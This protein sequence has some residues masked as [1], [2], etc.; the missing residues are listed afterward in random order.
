MKKSARNPESEPHSTPDFIVRVFSIDS[1]D[2]EPRFLGTGFLVA[3]NCVVTCAHIFKQSDW[4]TDIDLESA[5][6]CVLSE[7]AEKQINIYKFAREY[8]TKYDLAVLELE[9]SI[10]SN[11]PH[12][13][14]NI[15]KSHSS[16]LSQA[17]YEY[18]G[19]AASDNAD[20]YWDEP[21]VFKSP[22]FSAGVLRK[23]RLDGGIESG[24]SGSP[25]I[26]I[27]NGQ[28][29]CVGMAVVSGRDAP[30]SYIVPFDTIANFLESYGVSLPRYIDAESFFKIDQPAKALSD[31]TP[32]NSGEEQSTT[33]RT[34]GRRIS[35]TAVA[36]IFIVA[37]VGASEIW[38]KEEHLPLQN[39]MADMGQAMMQCSTPQPAD[40][41]DSQQGLRILVLSLHGPDSESAAEGLRIG[42]RLRFDIENYKSVQENLP[43]WKQAHLRTTALYTHFAPCPVTTHEAARKV[44]LAQQYDLVIWGQ[45]L[46]KS[47]GSG[48]AYSVHSFATFTDYTSISPHSSKPPRKNGD[49]QFTLPKQLVP[50][51]DIMLALYAYEKEQ[52]KVATHYFRKSLEYIFDTE[53]AWRL[54]LIASDAFLLAKENDVQDTNKNL[55]EKV[56]ISCAGN[57]HCLA[58]YWETIA[59]QHTVRGELKEA[60]ETYQERALPKAERIA[61]ERLRVNILMSIAELNAYHGNDNEA[62]AAALKARDTLS[63]LPQ[64]SLDRSYNRISGWL[65]LRNGKYKEAIDYYKRALRLWQPAEGLA[66]KGEMLR[67]IADAYQAQGDIGNAILNFQDSLEIWEKLKDTKR[68]AALQAEL[69]RI[70]FYKKVDLSKAI[71]YLRPASENFHSI[72]DTQNEARALSI[73][74][75]SYLDTEQDELSQNALRKIV[76][77]IGSLGELGVDGGAYECLAELFKHAGKLSKAIESINKA[78]KILQISREDAKMLPGLYAKKAGIEIKA[79]EFAAALVSY[80]EEARLYMQQGNSTDAYYTMDTICDLASRLHKPQI[81]D[82]LIKEIN[83]QHDLEYHKII[84]TARMLVRLGRH[85][86]ARTLFR[87]LSQLIEFDKNKPWNTDEHKRVINL[88]AQMNIARI[89]KWDTFKECMGIIVTNATDESRA[90]P[91]LLNPG[92][93]ITEL[94]GRCVSSTELVLDVARDAYNK[95]GWK[96]ISA[97][98]WRNGKWIKTTLPHFRIAFY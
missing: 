52:F 61:E 32:L 14:M 20:S 96:P 8:N 19:Y 83:N 56:R 45:V 30:N 36:I 42:A 90:S 81:C 86:E 41:P 15:R 22:K 82:D 60:L 65:E 10:E 66:K 93:I 5:R 49:V 35:G 48:K 28:R 88:I 9:S 38:N 46:P 68:Q 94:N 16:Y 27:F 64:V 57:D 84:H 29:V 72:N 58:H 23:I 17:K 7:G 67:D 77:I 50:S 25:V 70:Y 95:S 89:D 73:L 39:A 63:P 31:E 71:S 6:I 1:D 12:V 98:V 24:G 3:N 92:D 44:G 40:R 33:P 21:L 34:D 69:G 75:C 62:T 47:A 11:L 4:E 74:A 26:M 54:L 78:T 18:V 79:N 59:R 37:V 2:A 80:Q 85:D 53:D 76:P 13:I 55:L 43:I 91:L 51:I 97:K 87:R